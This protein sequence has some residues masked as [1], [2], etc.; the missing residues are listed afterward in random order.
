[1]ISIATAC[2]LVEPGL[3]HDFWLEAS[4]FHPPRRSPI[5]I[6]FLVGHDGGR[7]RWPL[8][9]ERI[10]SFVDHGPDGAIDRRRSIDTIEAQRSGG[11]RLSFTGEGTH[12]LAFESRPSSIE[13]P[14][15][16]FNDYAQKEGL[17]LAIRDRE[18]MGAK[19]A[20]GR[21]L[22]SR[23]A[24]ILVQIGETPTAN[25]LKPLGQTLEIVTEK[26]PYVL[27]AD[28][29]LP[30]QVLFHGE[31][32]SGAL[33]DLESLSVGVFP[34]VTK[35]T[36]KFGR[37]EFSLPKIGAWKLN[38]V[39]ATPCADDNDADFDTTFASLTF[40]FDQEKT[41]RGRVVSIARRR[42]QKPRAARIERGMH[43]SLK[44]RG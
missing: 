37:A 28:E 34:I 42:R 1:M 2:A 36:D 39:W 11:A 8:R 21:E 13:L 25:I 44:E 41:N 27:G 26:N 4:T 23:R 20:P 15:A 18:A 10:V 38:V 3:A 5:E 32:L 24:K 22:Y 7:S 12:V 9:K 40:G 43:A 31:P 29:M 6:D 30:V 35:T 19:S 33:V 16:R 17:T 14:A